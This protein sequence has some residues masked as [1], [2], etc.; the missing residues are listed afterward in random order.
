LARLRYFL[1]RLWQTYA[2]HHEGLCLLGD[3]L[4]TSANPPPHFDAAETSILSVAWMTLPDRLT[5][6]DWMSFVGVREWDLDQRVRASLLPLLRNAHTLSLTMADPSIALLTAGMRSKA[7]MPKMRMLRALLDVAHALGLV[8]PAKQ[9]HP[10][11]AADSELGWWILSPR[12]ALLG[13]TYDMAS[14]ADRGAYWDTLRGAC[15]HIFRQRTALFGTVAGRSK[16]RPAPTPDASPGRHLLAQLAGR[17]TVDASHTPLDVPPT[18]PT[19][20]PPLESMDQLHDSL[21]LEPAA[22]SAAGGAAASQSTA[23]AHAASVNMDQLTQSMLQLFPH[24]NFAFIYRKQNWMM[25]A[26]L[27]PFVSPRRCVLLAACC[28]L[29]QRRAVVHVVVLTMRC[30]RVRACDVQC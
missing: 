13:R 19:V 8:L 17:D 30:V 18:S 12:T 28:T 27:P 20:L 23:A 1:D 15:L 29:G 22:L 10:A 2:G 21:H 24:K 6:A 26:A 25:G 9:V 7:Y 4:Q 11:P 14:H 3:S 16:K 5:L